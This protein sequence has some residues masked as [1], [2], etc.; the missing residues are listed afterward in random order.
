[1][2]KQYILGGGIAGL[3]AAYYFKDYI[4]IA[5]K[6]NIGGQFN[7]KFQLG[8]RFIKFNLNLKH[9]LD[10]FSM[11][12]K[13]KEIKVGYLVGND[14][15]KDKITKNELSIYNQKIGRTKNIEGSLNSGSNNMKILDFNMKVLI[16]ILENSL[17]KQNRIIYGEVEKIDLKNKKIILEKHSYS[18]DNLISTIHYKDFCKLSNIKED[19]KC[20]DIYFY[21][22]REHFF[23]FIA[24]LH[25]YDFIYDIDDKYI[26]R[27]TRTTDGVVVESI[28]EMN[29][30]NIIKGKY[31]LKNAK[32]LDNYEIKKIKDVIFLGRYAELNQEIRV[33]NLIDKLEKMK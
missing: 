5:K 16:N 13:V 20:G 30:G 19:V 28:K 1:M 33:D 3:L 6:N 17:K 27:V 8:P 23:D 14:V 24:G 22:F 29:I 2:K 31:I 25:N 10:E 32:L 26:T 9:L 18:Y 11:P 21:L 12:Y 7:S 15:V 4:L